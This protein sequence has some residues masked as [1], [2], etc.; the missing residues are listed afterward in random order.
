MT[1]GAVGTNNFFTNQNTAGSKVA[2]ARLTVIFST[3]RRVSIEAI[4]ASLT[5]IA[6][7]VVLADALAGHRITSV[8][9]SITLTR[10]TPI[11]LK[12]KTTT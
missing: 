5:V 11:E 12:P 8:G 6:C 4:Y 10:N 2:W 7:G 9:M 3:L 1:F